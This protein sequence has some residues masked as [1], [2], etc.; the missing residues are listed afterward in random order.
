MDW[1]IRTY[2]P[3][4]LIAGGLQAPAQQ[5]TALPVVVGLSDLQVVLVAL[6]LVRRDTHAA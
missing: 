4:W 3:A 1:L 5:L 2:E 6:G